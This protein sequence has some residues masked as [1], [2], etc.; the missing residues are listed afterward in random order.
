VAVVVISTFAAT[1]E[2][3]DAVNEKL[4]DEM[5]AGGLVHTGGQLPDGRQRVIDVW[6]SEAD[7][8]SFRNNTLG[9]AVQEVAGDQAPVPEIEVYELHELFVAPNAG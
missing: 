1:K 3:Y 4:G 9:P 6:E 8:E 5:P 7:W 2:Q